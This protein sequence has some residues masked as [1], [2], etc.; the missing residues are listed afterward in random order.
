MEDITKIWIG[1]VDRNS[2]GS[3]PLQEVLKH[4]DFEPMIPEPLILQM[5]C[6]QYA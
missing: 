4:Q 3:K 6:F 5:N 1:L 2:K